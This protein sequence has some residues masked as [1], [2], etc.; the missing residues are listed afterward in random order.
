[1][2]RERG[3]FVCK[4]ARWQSTEPSSINL[5]NGSLVFHKSAT[6]PVGQP[7][8]PNSG[9]RRELDAGA[10]VKTRKTARLIRVNGRRGRKNKN[11]INV[12]VVVWLVRIRDLHKAQFHGQK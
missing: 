11:A 5:T 4:G 3:A 7:D 10:R 1:M 8:N 2:A 6:I 9:R 12:Y